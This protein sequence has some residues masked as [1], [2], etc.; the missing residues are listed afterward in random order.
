MSAGVDGQQRVF[1]FFQQAPT[2][3][4]FVVPLVERRLTGIE[5][6]A[7][8]QLAPLALTTTEH[9]GVFWYR[10]PDGRYGWLRTEHFYDFEV[11]DLQQL[12]VVEELS[13][14]VGVTEPW[15]QDKPVITGG[16]PRAGNPYFLMAAGAILV[17]LSAFGLVTMATTD[18]RDAGWVVALVMMALLLVLSV[19]LVIRGA[20]RL[21]WWRLARAEAR[22]RGVEL[23][24]KLTGLGV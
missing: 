14:A 10:D 2:A 1:R 24:D 17:G 3:T 8:R 4:E 19:L 11:N 13:E 23:P 21:R 20:T 18:P 7:Q 5:V 15:M 9:P 12:V 16:Q 22:R 6:S